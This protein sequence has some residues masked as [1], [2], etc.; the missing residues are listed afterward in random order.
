MAEQCAYNSGYIAART[1]AET[2]E[3]FEPVVERR[4]IPLGQHVTIWFVSLLVAACW[5]RL[6]K[7]VWYN[8]ATTGQMIGSLIG[9]FCCWLWFLRARRSRW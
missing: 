3:I 4:Q 6:F 9:L 8:D 5:L 2:G 1:Y 7:G